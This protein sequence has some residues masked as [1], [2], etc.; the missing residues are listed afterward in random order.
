MVRL[1]VNLLILIYHIE[2]C[3]N[4]RDGAID[5]LNSGDLHE[6]E[7]EVSIPEMVRLIV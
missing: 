3:F 7:E 2:G 1:I 6:T 4:S 5:R